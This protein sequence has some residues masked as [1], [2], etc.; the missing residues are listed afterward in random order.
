MLKINILKMKWEVERIRSRFTH[1]NR[2]E[3]ESMNGRKRDGQRMATWNVCIFY[4]HLHCAIGFVRSTKHQRK[5]K[6]VPAKMA[7]TIRYSIQ[8]LLPFQ[9]KTQLSTE[10]QS[11]TISPVQGW[12]DTKI[13][14]DKIYTPKIPIRLWLLNLILRCLPLQMQWLAPCTVCPFCSISFILL[15][16]I[17][18]LP[19]TRF[20]QR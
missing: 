15:V 7:M 6:S 9:I 1:T 4:F 14:K 12:C 5:M 16:F 17:L 18:H 19:D 8:V 3:S 20:S 10:T 2:S 11:N 13:D